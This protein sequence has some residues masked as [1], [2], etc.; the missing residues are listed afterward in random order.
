MRLAAGGK[1]GVPCLQPGPG[2]RLAGNM[3]GVYVFDNEMFLTIDF[4]K[5]N[6]VQSIF[7]KYNI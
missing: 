2:G 7:E 6:S 5:Q 4:L 1:L 3:D